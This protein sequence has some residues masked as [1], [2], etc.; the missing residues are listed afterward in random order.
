MKFLCVYY[1]NDERETVTHTGVLDKNKD[2]ILSKVEEFNSNG[3]PTKVKVYEDELLVQVG[4][5]YNKLQRELGN[6]FDKDTV[7]EYMNTI[8]AC[9]DEIQEVVNNY[10][11]TEDD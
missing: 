3:G 8:Q 4:E 2:E 6:R 10:N 1:T 9:I 11:S 5:R 7:G